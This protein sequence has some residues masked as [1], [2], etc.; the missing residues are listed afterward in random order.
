MVNEK[1]YMIYLKNIKGI[2]RREILEILEKGILPSEILKKLEENPQ[3]REKMLTGID[4]GEKEWESAVRKGMNIMTFL[5]ES[6][7]PLLKRISNPPLVIY[8]LGEKTGFQ[9]EL[10]SVVG[11][12]KPSR[13]GLRVA[14]LFC[15]KFAEY[16]IGVVSGMAIGIDTVAHKSVVENNGFTIA[17]LG[18]GADIP[19]PSSNKKLYEKILKSGCVIS[20]FPP[21]TKPAPYHFPLRNRIIAGISSGTVVCEAPERSGA[22]ITAFFAAE[23]SREVF[24]IPGDIFSEKS[25]GCNKLIKDGAIIATCPEDVIEILF[26]QRS[27]KKEEQ[28]GSPDPEEMK[29]LEALKG[30][31][32]HVDELCHALNKR[33]E[34]LLPLLTEMELKGMILNSGGYIMRRKK[35]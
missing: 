32:L 23:F 18:T 12:R 19:Y 4:K 16:G 7:P 22:L 15:S 2:S 25:K 30:G 5:D 28:M 10:V 34:E 3:T 13:Y 24:A 8:A 20:E 6:F 11:T 33:P 17:V 14:E 21:G 31:E 1:K 29:I 9:G 26:P 27:V 35:N